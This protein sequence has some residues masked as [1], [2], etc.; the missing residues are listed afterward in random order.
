M[1]ILQ[2]PNTKRKPLSKRKRLV[3]KRVLRKGKDTKKAGMDAKD[4]AALQAHLQEAQAKARNQ[5]TKRSQKKERNSTKN[6]MDIMDTMVNTTT[7]NATERREVLL[8][9]HQS[10]NRETLKRGPSVRNTSTKREGTKRDTTTTRTDLAQVLPK[11]RNKAGLR[12][13][14]LTPR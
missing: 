4:P 3:E 7:T 2:M 1:E 8:A 10:L 11:K 12:S 13:P 5:R 6:I 9:L 14:S